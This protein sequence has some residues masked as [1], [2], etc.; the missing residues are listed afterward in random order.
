MNSASAAKTWKTS[1]PPGGG[2]VEGLVQAPEADA[3]AAQ[4]ADDLDQVGQGAG[5]PVQARHDQGVAGAQ[6]V[7]AGRQLGPAGRPTR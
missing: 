4:R 3:S 2:G 5:E 1:R 6:V 7:Q